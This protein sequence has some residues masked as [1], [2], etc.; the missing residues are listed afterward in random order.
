MNSNTLQT[1]AAAAVTALMLATAMTSS[2]SQAQAFAVI[3]PSDAQ[4]QA[5]QNYGTWSVS[6]WQYVLSQSAPN[7]PLND[8]SGQNCAVDQLPHSRVFF[9]VGTNG[10]GN[11]NRSNCTVPAGK[12]LFFPL[13][14][15][16]DVHI[17]E[18]QPF[19]D[20]NDTVPKLWTDLQS[21]VGTITKL[22][23]SVDGVPVNLV[24]AMFRTCAGLIPP[25]TAPGFSVTLPDQNIFGISAGVYS[26]VVADG[27][28]LMLA[29]LPPG[30]HVIKFGG[31]GTFAGSPF[32]EDI[33]YNLIVSPR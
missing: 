6:W 25:C 31:A 24:P 7:N 33:T 8:L 32:S 23:A 26:P 15:F 21:L 12:F 19:G 18:G 5:G 29:P 27:Y 28:Y 1:F 4:A 17:P 3:P 14:N 30:A 10:P 20:P 22:Y 11:A 16:I 9:L 13:V 2:D